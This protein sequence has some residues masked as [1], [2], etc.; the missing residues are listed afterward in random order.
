MH[1]WGGLQQRLELRL[2]ALHGVEGRVQVLGECQGGELCC[3]GR[4]REQ[5]EL[6]AGEQDLWWCRLC[7]GWGVW[8]AAW[9][10]RKT[11]RKK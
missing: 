7:D 10:S 9:H 1:V 2:V 6:G 3:D 8:F 5:V 4:G 11:E